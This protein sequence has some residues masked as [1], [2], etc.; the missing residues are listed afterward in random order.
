MANFN[1]DNFAWCITDGSA[2][3]ISQV[4]GMAN[5]MNLDFTHKEV[6]IN[7]PWNI[8]PVGTVPIIESTFK[9]LSDFRKEDLPKFIISCGR[10]SVYLS[11]FLKRTYKDKVV[12]VHIQNPK[13]NFDEF[14][15]IVSPE[16]D[17]LNSSN[18]FSTNLAINHISQTL[19]KEEMKKF[20][21]YIGVYDEPVCAVLIGGKSNNY[22]FDSNEL[23]RFIK[24]LQKVKE[25]QSIKFF[26]LFSRRTNK[27]IIN[28]I[29]ATFNQTDVVW[30]DNDHNP[31]IAML[32]FSKYI[33]CTSDS[34]SMI[35][36]AITSMRS[37]YIYRLKSAKSKNRIEEFNDSIISMGLAKELNFELS[38][39]K[40]DYIN[41]T[42]IIANKIRNKFK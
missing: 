30:L 11:L 22:I 23:D 26:F 2:G 5:A 35:S 21:K 36:E 41:E 24:S 37:V 1:R 42:D 34:V 14:D 19:I 13:S 16:H 33:I 31:Y 40:H 12:T 8:L 17:N 4:K 18:I 29:N 3:M 39:F 32:G 27:S 38:E 20:S 28:K 7:F 6:K 9:N 10:K 15:V 25:N